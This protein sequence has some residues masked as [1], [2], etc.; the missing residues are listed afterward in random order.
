MKP[1]GFISGMVGNDAYIKGTVGGSTGLLDNGFGVT[2]MFSHWQGDGYNNS[3]DG[4]GQNYFLSFGYKVN[5]NHNL[6][7]LI[8]GA[9]QW[10]N[11]NF[12]N[13][14]SNYLK[15]GR[16]YNSNWGYLNG[17][18]LN[19][20]KNYYHKPV[21]NLNWDWTINDRS[22][23]STV[24]YGSWGRGGGT[25]PIGRATTD[26]NTGLKLFDDV[27]TE[28]QANGEAGYAIRASVNNHQWFGLVSNFNHKFSDEF[29]FNA[30]VDLRA[31]KG[32]HFRHLVDLMGADY[33]VD[34]TSTRLRDPNARLT[35]T[36]STNPWKILNGFAKNADEKY[37]YDYSERISY[38]GAFTQ[39]EYANDRFSAFFQGALSNQSHVRWDYYQYLP[40]D[41]ESEKVENVGYNLK[42][43][44]SYNIDQKHFF[45]GNTGYYSRQPYHDNIYMNYANDVNPFTENE[46]IF[47]IELG[48]KYVSNFY[49][50]NVNAYKTT[51]E[52]RVESGS[53]FADAD[54]IAEYDPNGNFGLQVD[55]VIYNITRGVKQDHQG[56][57]IDFQARPTAALS[58]NGFASFGNWKYS[59]EIVEEIRDEERNLIQTENKDV[60]GGKVGNAAQTTF[61]LGAEYRIIE[62]LT[63]DANFRNY[64]NLYAD[65]KEKDNLELPS[66]NLV[67]AGLSYNLPL[68]KKQ[69]L[70][71]RLNV[72]NVFNTIYISQS[73]TANHVTEETTGTYK[74]LDVTNQ[75]YFGYGRT[76]NFSAKFSF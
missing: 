30:G 11:Q 43:G 47:G 40:E 10:H 17:E 9:P 25:G 54:D 55:D 35:K 6:N 58:V 72:N 14:I 50:I 52:N 32:D 46:K 19:E 53:S 13:S 21:V 29:S 71:F 59:G 57:E 63:I 37:G 56:I 70:D 12:A 38:A 26:E 28:N 51:W 3:T 75:V 74:G 5:N 24:L 62:G 48:Y 27:F 23:L 49:T 36:F 61:G 34:G 20:R 2:A 7:L 44:L 69:A 31:Y 65:R 1:G 15:Y 8:T 22:S 18:E 76:W 67:D 42:T 16:K 68:N 33:L 39:F 60:D 45:F 66:Y 41:E 73:N 4:Q 64:A